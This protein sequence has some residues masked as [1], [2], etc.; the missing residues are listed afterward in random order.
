VNAI[1]YTVDRRPDTGVN[2]VQLGMWLFLASEAM[3]FAGFFSA[4]FMLRAGAQEPWLPLHDHLG[5]A[6]AGTLVLFAGTAVFVA[7]ARNARANQTLPLHAGIRSFRLMLFA[8]VLFALSFCALKASDY[9]SLLGAG[10]GPATSTRM[11]V[12]FLL[13]G[14]H[15]A[16]VA[17][18]L[19]VNVALLLTPARTWRDSPRI[20]VNR[21]DALALY[22]YFVDAVWVIVFV[23]LYVA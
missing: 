10:L 8:S 14:I 9:H 4:Y 1:P 5:R 18:G 22:W 15:L 7:G 2:N 17:G 23:L 3:L 16:H 20:V 21:L 13:T 19:L 11:A 6:A 12:Y